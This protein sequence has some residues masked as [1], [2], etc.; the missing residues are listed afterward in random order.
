MTRMLVAID[1]GVNGG[2]VTSRQHAEAESATIECHKMPD[3]EFGVCKL[4]ADI[5][6]QAREVVVY[7]EQPPLF[8]GKKIPGSSVGKMMWNAGILYGA[9]VAMGME[10]HRVTPPTW[11]KAHPVG[12][13][14]GM[15]TTKWKNKLKARA[16]ELFPPSSGVT[17]TLWNA[18]A[19]LILDAARRGAIA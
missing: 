12:T 19:L 11:Q 8:T 7:M 6:T 5:S 4:L 15:T 14:S 9:C 10:V 2:I 1:P 13:K 3:T 16:G 18:D 17:V